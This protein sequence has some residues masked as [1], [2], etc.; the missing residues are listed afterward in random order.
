MI[1][2]DADKNLGLVCL[3]ADDY[4]RRCI[5]ELAQTHTALTDSDEDPLAATRLEISSLIETY[6]DSLPSMHRARGA[7]A[8]V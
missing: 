8:R 3:D 7:P 4:E 1:F 2:V 5:A 6:H